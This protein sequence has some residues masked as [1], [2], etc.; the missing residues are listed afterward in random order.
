MAVLVRRAS[1]RFA[2]DARGAFGLIL[3]VGDEDLLIPASTGIEPPAPIR[4]PSTS[5]LIGPGGGRSA[6]LE[7]EGAPAKRSTIHPS[8]VSVD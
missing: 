4:Q 6:Q 8:A 7:V 2:D 3:E 1:D 5:A